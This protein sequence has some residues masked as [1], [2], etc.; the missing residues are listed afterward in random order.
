[1]GWNH[2][3]KVEIKARATPAA[4]WQSLKKHNGM[5]GAP[6]ILAL[7]VTSARYVRIEITKKSGVALQVA[8]LRLFAPL[9]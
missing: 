2:G 3:F 4:E 5:L 7:P 8:E 9:P 6:P 1:V